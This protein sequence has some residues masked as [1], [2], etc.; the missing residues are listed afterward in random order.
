MRSELGALSFSPVD[1][2]H[3]WAVSCPFNKEMDDGAPQ[4]F[5]DRWGIGWYKKTV[6]LEE[7]KLETTNTA[8]VL[9]RWTL[10]KQ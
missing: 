3:D 8:T 2:P 7:K 4:G 5:R 10:Q 9:F 6:T 1:L